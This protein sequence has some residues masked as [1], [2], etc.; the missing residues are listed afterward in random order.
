MS[1]KNCLKPVTVFCK[2]YLNN[3][4]LPFYR[5]LLGIKLCSPENLVVNYYRTNKVV[6]ERGSFLVNDM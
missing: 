2:N 6:K 4:I 5:H 3:I 1:K